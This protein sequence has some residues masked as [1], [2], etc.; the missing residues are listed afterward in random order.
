MSDPRFTAIA[1][2]IR[3]GHITWFK[4]IFDHIPVSL[5][6]R[7]LKFNFDKMKRSVDHPGFLTMDECYAIAR[8]LGVKGQE[9]VKLVNEQIE[10]TSR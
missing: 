8:L 2:L 5:L 9:V 3:S 4:D 6:S 7:E 10:K 1:P